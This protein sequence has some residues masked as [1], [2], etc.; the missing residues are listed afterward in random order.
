M[1]TLFLFGSVKGTAVSPG[2][3][4]PVPSPCYPGPAPRTTRPGAAAGPRPA[5]GPHASRSTA[6]MNRSE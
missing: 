3:Y 5:D 4:R 1:S 2:P 6:R